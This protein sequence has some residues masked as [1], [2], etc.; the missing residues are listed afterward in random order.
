MLSKK[1]LRS[2]LNSDLLYA[3]IRSRLQRKHKDKPIEI[4]NRCRA[5]SDDDQ[6]LEEDDDLEEEAGAMSAGKEVE[7]EDELE[8]EEDELEEDELEEDVEDAGVI[9]T[10][11]AIIDLPIGFHLPLFASEETWRCLSTK[12]VG[13]GKED[14]ASL[15]TNISLGTMTT[16]VAL[17]RDAIRIVIVLITILAFQVS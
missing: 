16:M 3:R 9:P 10:Y 17:G 15:D 2:A 12:Q 11:N 13:G 8:E 14:E 5:S 4:M 7:D 1:A 6:E